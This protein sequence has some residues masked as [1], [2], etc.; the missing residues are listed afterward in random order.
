MW[1]PPTIA[2]RPI[3]SIYPVLWPHPNSHSFRSLPRTPRAPQTIVNVLPDD[4]E[5]KEDTE[6]AIQENTPP[7][8]PARTSGLVLAI[9]NDI[10]S[11]GLRPAEMEEALPESNETRSATPEMTTETAVAIAEHVAVSIQEPAPTTGDVASHENEEVFAL[12]NGEV[13]HGASVPADHVAIEICEERKEDMMDV[14]AKEPSGFF[15][16]C[17]GAVRHFFNRVW[18]GLTSLFR[19]N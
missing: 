11:T 14:P 5:E 7:I 3:R 2:S 12:I 18:T 15:S 16:K 19:R 17:L 1:L 4:S 6:G 9:T 13:I 8:S 10:A